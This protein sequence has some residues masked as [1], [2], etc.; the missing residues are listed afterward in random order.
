MIETRN[1]TE[2]NTDAREQQENYAD[3]TQSLKPVTSQLPKGMKRKS[4]S[5]K[6]YE[7]EVGVEEAP[8]R[9]ANTSPP[10]W[11]KAKK[12]TKSNNETSEENQPKPR[13]TT[14]DLEFDYDRSQ[15][16]DQRPTP[17]RKARPRYDCFS[18]PPT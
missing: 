17:G 16:R 14:P 12:S 15:L 13:L 9:D 6:Q 10:T 2:T 11:K 1:H 7:E 5:D 3:K 18:I 8:E 4:V